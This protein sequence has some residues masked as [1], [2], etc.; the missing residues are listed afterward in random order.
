M[1]QKK[2]KVLIISIISTA[3]VIIGACMIY[4]FAASKP[5]AKP[6]DAV[7]NLPSDAVVNLPSDAPL[8]PTGQ[9]NNANKAES[10]DTAFAG[11]VCRRAAESDGSAF[12]DGR[13]LQHRY[14]GGR[15]ACYH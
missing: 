6:S 13:W 8:S 3:A 5:A 7:V 2:T 10:Y 12:G 9:E 1:D 15:A 11:T 4:I 14:A